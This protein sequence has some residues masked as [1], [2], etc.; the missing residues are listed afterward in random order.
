M[1]WFQQIDRFSVERLPWKHSWLS[2]FF[3]NRVLSLQLQT[4][5]SP[6]SLQLSLSAP[7]GA[8]GSQISSLFSQHYFP[9]LQLLDSSR[10]L[11]KCCSQFRKLFL[12]GIFRWF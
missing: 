2:P 8:T 6:Q 12:P 7:L 9:T 4:P 10:V 1:I 11:F 5:C 3:F